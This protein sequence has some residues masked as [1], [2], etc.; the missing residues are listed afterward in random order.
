[1]FLNGQ[2]S[3]PEGMIIMKSCIGACI[4]MQ[5]TASNHVCLLK[6]KINPEFD[7]TIPFHP[8]RRFSPPFLSYC[9]PHLRPWKLLLYHNNRSNEDDKFHDSILSFVLEGEM[10][11]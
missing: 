1:M 11:F 5:L 9:P 10:E 2:T 6:F 7:D 8:G 4:S 3:L